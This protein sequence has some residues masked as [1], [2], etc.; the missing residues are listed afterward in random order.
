[1]TEGIKKTKSLTNYYLTID[2]KR[3]DN[4]VSNIA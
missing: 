1:M 2:G 4:S 3:L